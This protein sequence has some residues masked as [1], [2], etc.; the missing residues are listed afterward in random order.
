MRRSVAPKDRGDVLACD[1]GAVIVAE[2]GRVP[3]EALTV[4]VLQETVQPLSGTGVVGRGLHDVDVGAAVVRVRLGVN[5]GDVKTPWGGAWSDVTTKQRGRRVE[6]RSELR[7]V[8]PG[9]E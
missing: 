5:Y 1:E 8:L 9:A 6:R 7:Q 4:A 2:E 3:A